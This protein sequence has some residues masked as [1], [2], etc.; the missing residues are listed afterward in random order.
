MS[1]ER[2]RRRERERE[3]YFSGS[4]LQQT[5]LHPRVSFRSRR[6]SHCSVRGDPLGSA[7]RHG[8]G[9]GA[10]GAIASGRRRRPGPDRL[11][12]RLVGSPSLL[13]LCVVPFLRFLSL[14]FSL[15]A[16]RQSSLHP[17]FLTHIAHSRRHVFLPPLKLFLS[18][19]QATFD[20]MPFPPS[21]PP[22]P[23]PR[24]A[25]GARAGR[26]CSPA[27]AAGDNSAPGVRCGR[28][29]STVSAASTPDPSPCPASPPSQAKNALRWLELCDWQNTDKAPASEPGKEHV[30]VST[31][32][33]AP[34]SKAR[35]NESAHISRP[36]LARERERL[37]GQLEAAN[38]DV[39][40]LQQDAQRLAAELVAAGSDTALGRV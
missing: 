6:S 16:L 37:R 28:R 14:C 33:L 26:I 4:L 13:L 8:G 25:Q 34:P 32:A 23:S 17:F 21:H 7:K 36:K 10:V 24:Q 5:F 9:T 11:R 15:N 35:L 39:R 3:R 19:P 31:A 40:A 18:L 22:P 20:R 27:A 38:R 12:L 1:I 30:D 29:R 2:Q